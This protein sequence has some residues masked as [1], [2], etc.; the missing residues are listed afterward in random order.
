MLEKGSVCS[1][2]ARL[3]LTEAGGSTGAV[4][5]GSPGCVAGVVSGSEIETAGSGSTETEGT[6]AV[7][8]GGSVFCPL[9]T[10]A[11][12]ESVAGVESSVAV[13]G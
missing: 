11:S 1:R 3:S 4:D 13:V 7:A 12:V 6:C 10:T 5:V 2:D 8:G 9:G